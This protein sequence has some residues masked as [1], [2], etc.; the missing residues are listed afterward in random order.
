MSKDQHEIE[1]QR[2]RA[3]LH[4]HQRQKSLFSARLIRDFLL[5]LALVFILFK[6]YTHF[7]VVPNFSWQ[8]QMMI[9]AARLLFVFAA[10][11]LLIAFLYSDEFNEH[12]RCSRPLATRLLLSLGAGATLAWLSSLAQLLWQQILLFL[13]PQYRPALKTATISLISAWEKEPLLALLGALL[14]I[15]LPTVILLF[16]H[17]YI[18]TPSLNSLYKTERLAALIGTLLLAVLYSDRHEFLLS[19]LVF[20]FLTR[21]SQ[22][23]KSPMEPTASLFACLTTWQ[24]LL[25]LFINDRLYKI[26]QDV[27]KLNF[28]DLLTPF[29]LFLLAC[30]SFM[31]FWLS[32]S[33]QATIVRERQVG[34]DLH[35]ADQRRQLQLL[36]TIVLGICLALF[37]IF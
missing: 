8:Q 3:R 15:V 2:R 14:Q 24:I 26:P 23:S 27:V 19:I 5:A 33:N 7:V 32:L 20:Y 1:V 12:L 30:A 29:M 11:T 6:L 16:F 10:P 22:R 31:P 25:P 35:S 36:T 21:L 13:N 18:L 4:I 9:T 28:S 37:I 17:I 34:K